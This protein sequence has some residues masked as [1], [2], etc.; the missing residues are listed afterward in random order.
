MSALS[1]FP[2]DGGPAFGCANPIYPTSE[3]NFRPGDKFIFEV[4]E[5]DASQLKSL[6]GK[7]EMFGFASRAFF[8]RLVSLQAC[9]STVPALAMMREAPTLRGVF[10]IYPTPSVD[11]KN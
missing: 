9:S 2:A 11:A 1:I 7:P 10:E 5:R 6:L 3:P 4:L 8:A